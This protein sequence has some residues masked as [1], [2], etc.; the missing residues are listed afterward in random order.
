MLA[1]MPMPI[2]PTLLPARLLVLLLPRL[3]VL[4]QE[5]FL[6]IAFAIMP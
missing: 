6:G 3:E 5:S 4:A 2:R 1:D